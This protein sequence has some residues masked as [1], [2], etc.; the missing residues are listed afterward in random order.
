MEVRGGRRSLQGL[1]LGPGAALSGRNHF[2]AR[3]YGFAV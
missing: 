3:A 1:T 2:D